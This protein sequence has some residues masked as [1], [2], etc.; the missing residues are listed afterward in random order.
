MNKIKHYKL[1]LAS[2]ILVLVGSS[3]DDFLSTPPLDQ[4]SSE[5][6]YQNEDQ[7]QMSVDACYR[8]LPSANIILMRDSWSDNMT[9]RNGNYNQIG[10][11]AYTA[12]NGL[13]RDEWKYSAVANINEVLEQLA[14]HSDF[15]ADF[16]TKAELELRF[17]RAFIY[18]DMLFYFGDVPL[19]KTTLTVEESKQT[20]RAPRADVLEFVLTELKDVAQNIGTF[21]QEVSG[22]IN[23]D[24]V[25][26]YL[27][28]VSLY[29]KN[30]ADAVEYANKVIS[31]GKFELFNDY[32][33]LFRIQ[34]DGNTKEV[35]FERQ[36]SF[37]L[38]THSNN[39]YHSYPSS[40]MHGW[41][42]NMPLQGLV[43]EYECA[44]GHPVGQCP[45]DCVYEQQRQ[46]AIAAG[47]DGEYIGRDPRLNATV[48]Y[49]GHKWI[50]DG[51][52]LS[53]YGYRDPSSKDYWKNEPTSNGYMMFKWLD[54]HG[55]EE[56]RGKSGKN[57]TIIRYADVL[58]MKAEA[59]VEL[60]KDF[61]QVVEILNEIRERAGMPENITAGS[62]DEM[63]KAVRHERRIELACEG[64]RYQDIIRW[65]ICDQVK[66]GPLLGAKRNKPDGT[67]EED[68]V[69]SHTAVW[70]D[71]MY[72]FPIPQD[73][74]DKNENITPNPGW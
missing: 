19:I 5:V 47:Q 41:L 2:L 48:V 12:Y 67:L 36:Y 73:V 21:N 18:Y 7:A 26:A 14:E 32:D 58:L 3:C 49:P 60:N 54:L 70:E 63:R 65:R 62:Q 25:N 38:Y 46:A 74:M 52:T 16:L 31:S 72:L 55:G 28:R 68:R 69:V 59:L 6:W 56:E 71:Y 66:N 20:T 10:S 37:P 9:H 61:D 43:G 1:I 51:K 24:V 8:Y 22:R 30:Y 45:D 4:L 33:G 27:A 34:N 53:E 17:I 39:K 44:C 64:L 57:A 50:V 35:I 29:E 13:V 42:W 11:G 15:D 40:P 23:A